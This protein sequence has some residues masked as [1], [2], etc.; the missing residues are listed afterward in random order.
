MTDEV[1]HPRRWRYATTTLD[2]VTKPEVVGLRNLY[3]YITVTL[4]NIKASLT[5]DPQT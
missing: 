5:Q 2:G 4:A 1:S 3:C